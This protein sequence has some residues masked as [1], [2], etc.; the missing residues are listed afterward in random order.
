MLLKTLGRPLRQR[1]QQAQ[2]HQ[3]KETNVID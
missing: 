2:Q 3:A 1:Q